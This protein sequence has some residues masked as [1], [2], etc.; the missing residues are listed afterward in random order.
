VQAS[1]NQLSQARTRLLV[2]SRGFVSPIT[3]DLDRLAAPSQMHGFVEVGSVGAGLR[4]RLTFDNGL[5]LLAGVSWGDQDYLDVRAD[6]GLTGTL[7]LRY[8]PTGMGAS[9]PFIEIGGLIGSIDNLTLTRTYANG[10]GTATGQ[11]STNANNSAIYGRLGWIWDIA[12]TDQLGVY[13]EYGDQ[14]QTIGGYVE[15]LSRADP[16]EAHVGRGVDEMQVGKIGL[17]YSHD[18]NSGWELG[19]G[20][21]VAHAFSES[22]SLPVAI[23]GFGFVPAAKVGDQ[24]WAEFGARVGHTFGR[25][26]TLSLFVV[27]IAGSAAVGSHAD[28]GLDYKVSF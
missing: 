16:F 9:R 11:G 18:F 10:V 13:G 8:A 2:Q 24:T 12:K 22:Q 6:N 25:R 26:S 20:L 28:V 27:G 5:M 23:P 1:V 7:A 21:A 4:G 17:R 19:G 14:R 3:D 15:P